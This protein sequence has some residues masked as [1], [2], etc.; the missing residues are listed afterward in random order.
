MIVV[1]ASPFVSVSTHDGYF[2]LVNF[3]TGSIVKKFKNPD[4]TEIGKVS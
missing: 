4:N 3:A 2:L 1:K